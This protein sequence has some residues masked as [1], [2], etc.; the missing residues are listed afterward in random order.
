VRR[1]DP[2]RD[3]ELTPTTALIDCLDLLE[4]DVDD[5]PTAPPIITP[6]SASSAHNPRQRAMA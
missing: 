2:R 1:G 4:G 6:H 5:V 3:A